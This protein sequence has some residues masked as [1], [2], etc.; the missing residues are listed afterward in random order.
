MALFLAAFIV[1]AGLYALILF[2]IGLVFFIAI[3]WLATR[4]KE[5]LERRSLA[6]NDLE[7]DGDE[8]L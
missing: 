2:A 3:L 4:W 7:E 5:R 6:G 8:K 1:R